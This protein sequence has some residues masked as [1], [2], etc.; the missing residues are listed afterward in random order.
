MI[1]PA[2]NTAILQEISRN[3]LYGI[4]YAL[5]LNP[6]GVHDWIQ[7]NYPGRV[8]KMVRGLEVL[9]SSKRLMRE[10]LTRQARLSGNPY[11]F[12]KTILQSIKIKQA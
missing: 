6:R 2:N 5:E 1:I 9:N 11:A 3:P 10:F 7:A 12:V 8:N 4:D